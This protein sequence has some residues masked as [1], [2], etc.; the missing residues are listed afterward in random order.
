[1]MQPPSPASIIFAAASR[2][3]RKT[4]VRFTSITA[5]H[6]SSDIFDTCSPSLYLR[7]NASRVMPALLTSPCK[8]PKSLAMSSNSFSTSASTATFAV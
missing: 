2:P 3:Q 8:E 5:C 7:V 1:M 4:P 6:C